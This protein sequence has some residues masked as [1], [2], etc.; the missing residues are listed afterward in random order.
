MQSW[1]LI[2]WI[3]YQKEPKKKPPQETIQHRWLQW[4]SPH[5]LQQVHFPQKIIDREWQLQPLC[6]CERE[7]LSLYLKAYFYEVLERSWSGIIVAGD[8][9]RHWKHQQAFLTKPKKFVKC[10]TQC[11]R[12]GEKKKRRKEKSKPT[13]L[14]QSQTLQL[15]SQ[16]SPLKTDSKVDSLQ[17]R[18]LAITEHTSENLFLSS[19]PGKK[20]F[21]ILEGIRKKK[22]ESEWTSLTAFSPSL[23]LGKRIFSDRIL[24]CLKMLFAC[25]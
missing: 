4:D 25:Y 1:L 5:L 8:T 23:P 19:W 13:N 21:D 11:E 14:P 15:W 22:I 3:C 24:S 6:V 20:V 10:K 17:R 7:R 9:E 16:R 12:R 2:C 18:V